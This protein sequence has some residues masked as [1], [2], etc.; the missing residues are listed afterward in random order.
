[1]AAFIYIE[2]GLSSD[3][4]YYKPV[5]AKVKKRFPHLDYLDLDAFSEEFLMAQVNQVVAAADKCAVYFNI[6]DTEEPLGAVL[7]LAE[8]LIRR[9][10]N[11]Q[12]VLQ[13]PHTRL[14][15]LFSNR[16]NLNFLKNPDD[17]TL[18]AHLERFFSEVSK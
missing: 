16:Q 12:V 17:S 6:V 13:G 4:T 11:T 2:L 8:I 5:L 10:E 7:P 3:Y 14:E 9:Q 18:I 15:R 1:M